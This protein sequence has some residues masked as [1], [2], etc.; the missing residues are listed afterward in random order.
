MYFDMHVHSS[1]SPC[2]QL[3]LDEILRHAR[4][5]GLDGVCITD[6]DTMEAR[7]M[8]K[9]GVQKDGL[10][11]IVGIE[12]TTP[13][14][15]F[16][17]FGPFER[18]PQQLSARDLLTTVKK[19]GGAAIAAHPFREDR[20]TN[21]SLISG[22]FCK[23]VEGINGRNH[24]KE[25]ERV[26]FWQKNYG[27]RRIGGSDA[28]NLLELGNVTTFFKTAIKTRTD[29]ITALRNGTFSVSHHLASAVNV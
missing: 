10:C 11:V 22:G 6:H 28:H 4:S 15:D 27:I 12:Y 7:Y 13:E 29:L 9:E 17:L 3:D 21:E 23:I 2:S 26:A 16:L 20:G 1:I 14:G 25:N 18:L 24:N 19:L 5:I 8:L